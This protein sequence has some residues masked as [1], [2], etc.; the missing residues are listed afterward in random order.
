M[1]ATDKERAG[2]QAYETLFVPAL[3]APW[4]GRVVEAAGLSPGQSVIDIGCGTGVLARAAQSAVAPGGRVIG[5]DPA[6]G[7]IAVARDIAPGIDWRVGRA[8]ALE[9]PD[10]TLDAA[11]SQF[12]MMFFEDRLAASREA[13]RVL[14]PGGRSAF[15]VWDDIARNPAYAD[16]AAFL[17]GEIGRAAGDAIRVPFC[18]GDAEE[19]TSLLLAAGF[20]D[21]AVRT[22]TAPVR[23][24][25]IATMVEAEIRGWLPLFGIHVDEPRLAEILDAAPEALAR[26]RDADGRAAFANSAHVVTARR[27]D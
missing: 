1:A 27:P 6:P 9:M 3:F 8:E 19:V 18:L 7:M 4:A 16:L 17:D 26:H 20:D 25:D 23:F 2:A 24:A 12:A 21:L 15:A 5:V 14:R 22:A 10:R 13:F 11:V